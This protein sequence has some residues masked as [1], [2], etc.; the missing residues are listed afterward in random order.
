MFKTTQQSTFISMLGLRFKKCIIIS[1]LGLGLK[2]HKGL[3]LVC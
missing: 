1:M 3:Y 2:T